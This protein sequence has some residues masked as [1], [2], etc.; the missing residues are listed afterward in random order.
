MRWNVSDLLIMATIFPGKLDHGDKI[1]ITSPAGAVL[2]EYIH[3]AA[4][5]ISQAGFVPVI[6]PHAEGKAGSYSGTV[7]QRWSD[8]HSALTD[9]DIKA[10]LCARGGYGAVHLL[11][12]LTPSIIAGN[13]KWII[14]F[15]DISALHAA[16]WRAG[17]ASIHASMC[18]HLALKGYDDIYTAM[19]FDVLRGKKPTYVG[20]PNSLNRP[21]E[22]D[23]TIVGGNFAVLSNLAGTD[24]DIFRQKDMILFIEDI[25]EA[26]Y[27]VERMLYRLILSGAIN[28]LRGLIVGR[29]TNYSP[30]TLNHE[31][32][33]K[34]IN[35]VMVRY[36]I[37]VAF[38][39]PIGHV[40]ENVSII[41]GSRV[42]FRVDDSGSRL[43]II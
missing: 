14:G 6:M 1:A 15:S 5:V 8:L 22:S 3:G 12:Y 9:P 4:A 18:K 41:E 32:I 39:F 26:V 19:L 36:D 29:F 24:F 34:M 17:V 10:I 30:D 35:R 43:E 13:P 38:D 16:W 31:D 27:K 33:P 40:D 2:P 21:G 11:E 25:S 23:G 20:F 28:N 7:S 37:P 42:R